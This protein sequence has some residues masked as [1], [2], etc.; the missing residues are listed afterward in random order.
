MS[1]CDREA[2]TIRRPRSAR[3]PSSHGKISAGR[4][5]AGSSSV[6]RLRSTGASCFDV[7]LRQEKLCTLSHNAPHGTLQTMK[8]Q[9]QSTD[10]LVQRSIVTTY[11]IV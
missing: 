7:F 3:G 9:C 6:Q 5:T 11:H 1:E 2:S 10:A 8:R 4:A